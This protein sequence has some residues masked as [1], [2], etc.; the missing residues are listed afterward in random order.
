MPVV[1]NLFCFQCYKVS[2]NRFP[3]LIEYDVYIKK[4]NNMSLFKMVDP[5]ILG[6]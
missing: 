2:D 1:Q 3:P 4:F 5:V 6:G